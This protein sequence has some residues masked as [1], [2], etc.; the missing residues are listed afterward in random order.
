[1]RHPAVTRV[2]GSG[3][4]RPGIFT[5]VSAKRAVDM[6]NNDIVLI[7]VMNWSAP[8]KRT[9][10]L[11]GAERREKLNCVVTRFVSEIDEEN[12]PARCLR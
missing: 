3:H 8:R 12:Q 7:Q 6:R 11:C 9:E 2:L 4:R 1:M 5:W 10:N